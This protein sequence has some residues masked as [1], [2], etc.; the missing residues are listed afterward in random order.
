M[1]QD[2]EEG[3]AWRERKRTVF[4]RQKRFTRLTCLIFDCMRPPCKRLRIGSELTSWRCHQSLDLPSAPDVS[5]L[6]PH[7]LSISSHRQENGGSHHWHPRL[8]HL[9]SHIHRGG[10]QICK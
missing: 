3:V 6:P 10:A 5:L 9:P 4:P 2:Q 8:T 7:H 1:S